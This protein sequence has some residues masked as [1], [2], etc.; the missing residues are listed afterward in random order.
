MIPFTI[1]ICFS[2][3]F[4]KL[5]YTLINNNNKLFIIGSNKTNEE[6]RKMMLQENETNTNQDQKVHVN[7]IGNIWKTVFDHKDNNR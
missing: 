2:L 1:I 6:L 7:V 3:V 5:G 4:W